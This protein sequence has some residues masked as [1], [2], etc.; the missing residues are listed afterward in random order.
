MEGSRSITTPSSGNTVLVQLNIVPP[1][2]SCLGGGVLRV[3]SGSASLPGTLSPH[4]SFGLFTFEV[5]MH[6]YTGQSTHTRGVGGCARV[7]VSARV[8]VCWCAREGAG[9]PDITTA[10]KGQAD[11]QL[12]SKGFRFPVLRGPRPGHDRG[13]SSKQ[14]FVPSAA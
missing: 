7:C 12:L 6:V 1:I 10:L 3:L 11:L 5:L 9:V 14:T 8:F 2:G 4:L 13:C